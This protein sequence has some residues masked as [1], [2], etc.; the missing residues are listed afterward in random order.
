MLRMIFLSRRVVE[1][2]GVCGDSWASFNS[3]EASLT[4]AQGVKPAASWMGWMS[5]HIPQA[6]A[7]R[8]QRKFSV[9]RS[10]DFSL[11]GQLVRLHPARSVRPSAALCTPPRAPGIAETSLIWYD[12]R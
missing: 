10:K 7:Q 8:A 5:A 3:V 12:R 1:A 6:V 11:N 2:G 4:R 9:S